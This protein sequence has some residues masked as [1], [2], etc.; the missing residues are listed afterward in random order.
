MTN[1]KRV[2]TGFN[3]LFFLGVV[4]KEVFFDKEIHRDGHHNDHG[5]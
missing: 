1:D 5:W 3:G 4:T 2:G